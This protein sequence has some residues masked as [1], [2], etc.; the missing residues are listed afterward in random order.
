[1]ESS[2]GEW[3][4]SKL[5]VSGFTVGGFDCQGEGGMIFE[6]NTEAYTLPC[7]KQIASESC[8][9]DA[10]NPEPE[11]CDNLKGRG[12]GERG[13][14]G[15]RHVDACGRFTLMYGGGHP[16]IVIILQLKLIN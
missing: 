6:N 12:G 8:M 5:R 3:T 10:G 13:S 15:R 11:L 16:S 2:W 1:M 4:C 7:E 9:Y 14:R